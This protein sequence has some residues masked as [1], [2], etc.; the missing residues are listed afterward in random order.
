MKVAGID[1]SMTSPA[2]CVYDT[3]KP[4]L[5][6]NLKFFNINERKK[7]QGLHSNVRIDPPI[8]WKTP[9]ERYDK[10]SDWAMTILLEE[11]VTS[12]F[13][14]GYSMGSNSG[15]VFNIA[16]NTGAL[17]HKMYKAGIKVKSSSPSSVKKHFTGKGNAKKEDMCSTFA[18]RFKVKFHELYGGKEA[19]SP[20]NDLV[21]SF[22]NL[23]AG[24]SLP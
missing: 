4:M 1:Y 12:V 18:E 16:E 20:E 19:D 11:G 23:E 9:E 14:E 22:A 7:C 2:I 6:E 5:Y 3:D 17:K 10:I 8:E 13:L 15:L 24:L 21:D